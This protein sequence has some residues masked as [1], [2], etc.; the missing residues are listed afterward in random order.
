MNPADLQPIVTW[1][2]NKTRTK[3][4]CTGREESKVA[5]RQTTSM[6]AKQIKLLP[7]LTDEGEPRETS[8]RGQSCGN[9]YE[10]SILCKSADVSL[11]DSRVGILA[12]KLYKLTCSRYFRTSNVTH[13]VINSVAFYD[14][15]SLIASYYGE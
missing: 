15:L 6:Q 14:V 12:I 5:C 13:L 8:L 7:S 10:K 2:M 11:V 4:C 1:I 3:Y 9:S